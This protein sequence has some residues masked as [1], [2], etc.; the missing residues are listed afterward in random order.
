M[1]PAHAAITINGTSGSDVIDV[2]KSSEPHLVLGKGG[3]DQILGGSA[4]D[5]L[6]GGSGADTIFGNDGNDIIIGGTAND[7]LH[8]GRGD[9]SFLVYGTTL[10]FDEIHGGEGFDSI[11]GSDG[12]DVIG[13]KTQPTSIELI[14]G[15]GGYDIIR[16]DDR[17]SRALNL[18]GITVRGIELIQGSAA[19]DTIVGSGGDDTI[20]G[21]RGNDI[22]NGGPGRDMAVFVGESQ[23]YVI[24]WGNP[25]TISDSVL[26][27]DG[28]DQ[29][30]SVEI[31]AFADG[32]FE[33][34]T[35][36]PRYPDNLAPIATADT[37]TL[38]E[39]SSVVIEVLTNDW[40]PDGDPIRVVSIGAA[41]HGSVILQA[42][43]RLLYTPRADFHGVDT[44]TYRIADD[45]FGKSTGTVTVTV[46]PQSDPPIAR[47]DSISAAAGRPFTIQPLENDRD[48][49]GDP[50]SLATV[51]IPLRGAA[52][53]GPG[54]SVVYTAPAG[55]SGKD[56]FS[57]TIVDTGGLS[58]TGTVIV[59][60][61]GPASFAEITRLLKDAPEGSWIKLNKNLFSSVWTPIAQRPC[62]TYSKPSKIIKAW[63][64][65]AF[66]S[67]RGDLI[68]WGGGHN[69]YCGNEVYR[70]RL[71]TLS[72]ERASLPSAIY[73]PLGDKQFVAVDGPLAAPIPAHTYDNS[74]YLPNLDRYITFGGGKYNAKTKFVLLDGVT[75]TGPYLWDPSR[76]NPQLVSGTT[77]SHFNP[78]LYPT[79][80]GGNM[81]D[82]RNT[83]VVRGQG[84]HR[85]ESSFINSTSA[86]APHLGKDAMLVTTHPDL[87]GKLYR[88]V[89]NDLADPD[90]DTWELVGIKDNS[91]SGKGAGAYDPGRNIFIRNAAPL[92]S[93]GSPFILAWDLNKAGP[94]NKNVRIELA[95]LSSEF[96]GETL[97]NCGTDFDAAR[98]AFAIWCTGR[99]VWY[100]TPPDTFGASGWSL[101]RSPIGDA[102]GFSPPAY[103]VTD[104]P[105][106]SFTGVLGKWKYARRFDIFL[107]VFEE[108]SGN[109]YAYKPFGWQ[110]QD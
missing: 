86:Y 19:N 74:E 45:K 88:Y 24:G 98:N 81:W 10:S 13:L 18:S 92:R 77:G 12:N 103:V 59:D 23:E 43:G 7:V 78:L 95:S 37:A 93:T 104:V 4:A 29:L 87:S 110:P 102:T 33:A 65:M 22:L 40:D 41:T 21:G 61:I 83:I 53:I 44:F 57:Y 108:D 79:V 32:H 20:L 25:I 105:G 85:P 26:K 34:G 64:S 49:D 38:P 80:F 67:N 73:D 6:D 90:Q 99:D 51:G 39:D 11:I 46:T 106:A 48:P 30:S 35:F 1:A 72:W 17:G 97:I 82:N 71:S 16:L 15:R 55:F 56:S 69:N 68:F 62:S 60:V 42:G 31:V 75:H 28:A 96:A 100:L 107:G 76:A 63:G 36:F 52:S 47:A 109:I 8:G 101:Q 89:I 54:N 66:D 3:A 5:T 84:A 14:D 9:D 50:I 94:T 91:Y 27:R 2:S 70:F 58:A